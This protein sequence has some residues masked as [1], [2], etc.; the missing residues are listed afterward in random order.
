MYAV[1][2]SNDFTTICPFIHEEIA[3]GKQ[4]TINVS[5]RDNLIRTEIM[6]VQDDPDA[7]NTDLPSTITSV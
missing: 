1:V 2:E 6:S 3:A 4:L 7:L 5:K